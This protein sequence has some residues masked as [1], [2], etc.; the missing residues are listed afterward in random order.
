MASDAEKEG[1]N[2]A[3]SETLKLT[4]FAPTVWGS[5]NYSKDWFKDACTQ[6]D[7]GFGADFRR[8]PCRI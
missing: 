3:G 8:R 1:G 7:A 4:A 2:L 5:A 6:A